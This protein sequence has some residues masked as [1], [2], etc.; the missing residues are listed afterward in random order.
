[1]LLIVASLHSVCTLAQRTRLHRN[2]QP[3]TDADRRLMIH[4]HSLATLGTQSGEDLR[5]YIRCPIPSPAHT[6]TPL[7]LG[8]AARRLCG[9][10]PQRLD[11][12]LVWWIYLPALVLLLW[13]TPLRAAATEPN[14]Y[15]TGTTA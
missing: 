2:D 1:M 10:T 12:M 4:H 11:D 15:Q 13:P 8:A 9:A 3:T 5:A 6:P 14:A 7:S